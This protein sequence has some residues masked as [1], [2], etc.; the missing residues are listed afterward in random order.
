MAR[1]RKIDPIKLQAMVE[2]GMT[3]AAIAK[4][5]GVSGGAISRNLKA[6]GLARNGDIVLRA[7]KTINNRKLDAMGQLGRIN[8]AIEKELDHIQGD[9]K[10]S[11]G[12]ERRELQEAQIKH[13]AEIRKQLSLLLDIGKALYNVEEIAAFQKI[14]L[15]EIGNESAECRSRILKRLQQRRSIT[16]LPGFSESRI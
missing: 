4:E 3:G 6:L 11:K 7:A 5:M 13:T 14:C 16:G 1:T 10:N 15:E 8:R 2:Q 12:T 9:L